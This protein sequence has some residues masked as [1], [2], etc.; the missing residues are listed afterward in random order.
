MGLVFS[1]CK[2]GVFSQTNQPLTDGQHVE[3]MSSWADGPGWAVGR[4]GV[5]SPPTPG[6]RHQPGAQPTCSW[7]LGTLL[8]DASRDFIILGIHVFPE[9]IKSRT[10]LS[11]DITHR[12]N[13]QEDVCSARYVPCALLRVLHLNSLSPQTTLREKVIIP[14]LQMEKLRHRESKGLA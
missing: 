13:H 3:E 1:A 2:C 7:C 11:V 9:I 6:T 10:S 5:G 14:V 12:D 4:P 8:W